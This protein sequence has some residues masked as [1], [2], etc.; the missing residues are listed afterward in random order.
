MTWTSGE[1]SVCGRETDV[2]HVD[3]HGNTCLVCIDQI[4]EGGD[5]L[6]REVLK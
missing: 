1:C 4:A 6:A 2:A 3:G 5:E